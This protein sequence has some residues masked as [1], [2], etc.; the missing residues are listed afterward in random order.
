MGRIVQYGFFIFLILALGNCQK[1]ELGPSV[2]INIE[3]DFY[4]DMF[5]DISNGGNVFNITV[6][7]IQNQDCLNAIIDY[8]I[9]SDENQITLSI[10]D[11]LEPASCIPGSAPAFVSIPLDNINEQN[12]YV[13][14]NLKDVVTNSGNLSVSS[15]DYYLKMNTEN[16]FEVSHDKLYKIPQ[17]TV[18]G[19]VGYEDENLKSESENFIKDLENISSNI[20]FS[21]GYNAGYYGYFSISEDRSISLEEEVEDKLHNTFIFHYD[22]DYQDINDLI[23]S[24]C[25]SNPDMNFYVFNGKGEQLSCP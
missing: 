4:I 14:I 5:E 8:S 22:A 12:Y 10:N 6:K 24:Y 20:S 23:S 15:D 19:Y 11:I 18:W 9:Y 16:G 21:E 13:Q 17:Y 2:I 25:N 1:S 7:S 3:D